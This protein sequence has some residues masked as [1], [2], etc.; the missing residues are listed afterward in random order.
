MDVQRFTRSYFPREEGLFD[1]VRG[2]RLRCCC[3]TDAVHAYRLCVRLDAMSGGNALSTVDPPGRQ[4][5]TRCG[6]ALARVIGI[7]GKWSKRRHGASSAPKGCLF[8]C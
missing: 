5:R 3:W 6:W 1:G 2:R 4:A 7:P 8:C